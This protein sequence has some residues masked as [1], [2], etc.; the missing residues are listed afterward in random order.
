MGSSIQIIIL[1]IA[2]V[3]MILKLRGVLGTRE[4]FEA[5]LKK[6]EDAPQ[7]ATKSSPKSLQVV[8]VEIDEDITNHVPADSPAARA[9][10]SMKQ[11]DGRFSVTEF[12]TGAR[13]AYEW[14]VVAFESDDL[15]VLKTHLSD[16]VYKDFAAV[17]KQRQKQGYRVD[18]EFIGVRQMDLKEASF[19]KDT[20]IARI[21]VAFVGELTSVVLD[22]KDKVIEGNKNRVKAQKDLWYF[23]RNMAE[24][25]PNWK[26]VETAG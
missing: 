21:G 12:L 8:Q 17:I 7:D 19:D 20:A 14:I 1:A 6:P 11:M 5:P 13:M 26:L 16:S 15:D 4:G 9:L 18:A 10:Q 25:D 22:A 23:V 2:A 3:F 24:D